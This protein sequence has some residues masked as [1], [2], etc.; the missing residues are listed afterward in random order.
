MKLYWS[1]QS[2]SIRILWLLEESGLEYEPIHLDIR[3]AKAKADPAF[4]AVSPMGKVPGFEDGAVRL[5]DSGAIAL[6][7]GDQYPDT[8]LGIPI[9]HPERGAYLQWVMFTNAVMEPAMGEKV[10]NLPPN[11]SQY[12]W[13]SWDLMLQTLRAGVEARGPFLFGEQ[14]TGA[15]VLLGSGCNFMRMFGMLKDDPVL[16]AYADRCIAR[17]AYQRAQAMEAAKL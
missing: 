11:P 15:D 13:G 7:V 4:R 6:Y 14:F 5:W 1:H 12:G 16:F 3:D 17:P 2:R 8:K 9:G 10:A